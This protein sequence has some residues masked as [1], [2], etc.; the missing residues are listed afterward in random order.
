MFSTVGLIYGIVV[1]IVLIL[2]FG[3]FLVI[4]LLRPGTKARTVAQATYCTLMMGM[5][6]LLMT[7]A[8][9][10]TV[11]SVFAGVSY[12]GPTYLALLVI[13]VGGGVLFL[14]HDHWLRAL[15]PASALIP[16]I[17]YLYTVKS[18]GMLAAILSGLSVILT[19][20]LGS[21]EEQWWAMPLTAF[22]YGLLLMWCTRS[23][24]SPTPLFNSKPMHT[25]P[26]SVKTAVSPA[27]KSVVKKTVRRKYVTKKRK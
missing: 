6:L 25:R 22:L 19:L 5:G 9:L 15:E 10:P 26:V 14:W 23:E 16:S 12:A 11:A 17:I 8:A 21:A 24:R 3:A 2:L 13:F 7:V 1:P 4:S 20:I 27:K 18:V